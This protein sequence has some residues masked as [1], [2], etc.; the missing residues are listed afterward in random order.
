MFRLGH[1]QPTRHEPG[2]HLLRLEADGSEVW[3]A[4]NAPN[5]KLRATVLYDSKSDA[6]ILGPTG[7]PLFPYI[8]VDTMM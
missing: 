7:R 4:P 3:P 5:D 2:T 6:I 1:L 8:I